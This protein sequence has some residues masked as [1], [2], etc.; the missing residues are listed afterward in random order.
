MRPED[1]G[2]GTGAVA[3][4]GAAA[5]ANAAL[6]AGSIAAVAAFL[7]LLFCSE[8]GTLTGFPAEAAALALI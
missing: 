6:P 2:G 4:K 1:P 5:A 3:G 7:T 8:G